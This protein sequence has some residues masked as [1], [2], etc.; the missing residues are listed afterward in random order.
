LKTLFESVFCGG[1]V[2]WA[3]SIAK[4]NSRSCDFAAGIYFESRRSNLSKI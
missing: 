4:Q 1:V 3:A 2:I